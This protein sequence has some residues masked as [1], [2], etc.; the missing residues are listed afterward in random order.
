MSGIRRAAAFL[1]RIGYTLSRYKLLLI[2]LDSLLMLGLFGMAFYLG[3]L[4]W[5]DSLTAGHLAGTVL[6]LL[7]FI[8][9]LLLRARQYTL[10][11]AEGLVSPLADPLHVEEKIWLHGTGFFS[12][13]GMRRRFIELPA[14]IWRTEL[15]EYILMAYVQVRGFP[16]LDAPEDERGLWYIFARPQDIRAVVAGFLYFGLSRRPALQVLYRESPSVEAA[17]YLSCDSAAQRDRLC[18]EFAMRAQVTPR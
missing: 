13:S 11:V 10:F 6:S 1:A 7:G 18:H 3:Y 5:R 9:L 14:V 2:R 4:G 12:V 17:F 16:L 15:D 8:T